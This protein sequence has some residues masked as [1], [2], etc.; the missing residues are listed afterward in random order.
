MANINIRICI[1]VVI[2][3]STCVFICIC[4]FFKVRSYDLCS[5][6]LRRFLFTPFFFFYYSNAITIYA[7]KRIT[8]K[9]RAIITYVHIQVCIQVRIS[10]HI[11]DDL[12]L[13]QVYIFTLKL[14]LV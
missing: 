5:L 9:S 14:Y 8:V 3:G 13:H 4:I 11:A 2:L 12:C 7:T 6:H 10:M 1:E